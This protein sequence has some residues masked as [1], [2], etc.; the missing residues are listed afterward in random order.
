MGPSSSVVTVM[1]RE[2]VSLKLVLDELGVKP[3]ISTSDN[4]KRVQ[5]AIY[6][7]QAAGLHLGYS[8]SWPLKGP[9]SRKLA[10]D[11]LALDDE[12]AGLS[13]EGATEPP[14]EL[15]NTRLRRPLIKLIGRIRPV[16][17]PPAGVDL[18]D[19]SWMWLLASLLYLYQEHY[20]DATR[21]ED[22]IKDEKMGLYP[23]I[24]P[25]YRALLGCGLLSNR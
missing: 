11:C 13:D 5:G 12:M 9:Y 16:L 3:S 4:C 15:P 20:P 21:V 22:A 6:L 8:Y 24:G 10:I 23:Y 18:D 14:P 25:G 7:L 17:T 19:A 1:N 2:L